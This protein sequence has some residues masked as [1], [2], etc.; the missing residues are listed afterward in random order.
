MASNILY[1]KLNAYEI[2][3]FKEAKGKEWV[4][5]G[6]R[7]DYPQQLLDLY[8]NAPKHRAIIDGKSDLIAGKGWATNNKAINTISEAK[9][10]DFSALVNPSESLYELTKKIS[11]DLEIFG[12]YYLQVI[13][14]NL[15]NDFDLYHVDF[16]KLRTN[17]AQDKFFYSNDWSAYN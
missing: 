9:L 12:G 11:L 1:V 17:K 2:P 16:S 6:E 3:K 15:R 10:I 7:N 13:Y 4:N 14:N 8:D 5:Y